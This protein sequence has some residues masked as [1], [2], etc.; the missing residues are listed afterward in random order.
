MDD[1]DLEDLK[2]LESKG[3][4]VFIQDVPGDIKEKKLIK[5]GKKNMQSITFSQGLLL[6]L[7]SV[8]VG[9]DFWLEGLFIFRPIIVSTLTG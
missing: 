6:A 4:E 8:I 3:I 2:Y 5:E 7:M 1:E 9:I